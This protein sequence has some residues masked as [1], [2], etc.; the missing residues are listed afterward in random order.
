MDEHDCRVAAARVTLTLRSTEAVGE[1]NVPLTRTFV[2]LGSIR[3]R[4]I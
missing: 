1:G 2:I 3:N 4:E